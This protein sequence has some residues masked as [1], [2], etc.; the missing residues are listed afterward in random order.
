MSVR[1]QHR[2]EEPAEWHTLDSDDALRALGSDSTRGLSTDDATARLATHGPNVLPQSRGH[3]VLRLLA[4]QFADVLVILLIAAATVAVFVGEPADVVAIVAILVLN[5]ILGFAQAYRAERALDALRALSAPAAQVRRDGRDA[6]I[7][8]AELVIGDIVLLDAGTIVPADLRLVE[9]RQL[10]VEEAAL[11][12]ESVPVDKHTRALEG[13]PPLGDRRNMAFAGTFVTRGR[14]AGLVVATATRTQLG[15]IAALLRT[16]ETAATPLQRRLARLG[17]ALAI[18]VLA[19]CALIFG[20][21]LLRG[22]PPLGMLM[23][24]LSLA[25]AAVPEALPAIVTMSLALGARRMA[26]RNALVRRLPAVETL[27]SVTVICS[28]K[29]GTLTENRMRL[30]QIQTADAAPVPPPL[31]EYVAQP[32]STLLELIALNNDVT[33]AQDATRGD[34]TELAL[35][36]A[37]AAAGYR[38]ETLALRYPRIAELPF[39]SER[40]RMTTLHRAHERVIA[41]MKGAPERVVTACVDRIGER[42]PMP[43]DRRAVLTAAHD[44]AASGLRVLAVSMRELPSMPE[45]LD[46]VESD[47]TFVGLVGLLDPPRPEA[48]DAVAVCHDAGIRVVMITG[49]HPATARAIAER[50]GIIAGDDAVLTGPE[51]AR[52]S[53]ADLETRVRNVRIFSRVAAEDK[54]RIVR[55]LQQ[56]GECVAMTGDGVNDAPALR[57]AEIG[58]A[59][60]RGG[61]DVA[62]EAAAMVLLDDNFATI[63]HA[64]EEGRR[65]YDNVRRFVRYTLSTNSG[66]LWTLFAAPFIGL[67]L[68]L[69]PVQIL[70][71]NLVTDGLP[72]LSLAMERPEPGVMRRKPRPPSESLFAHGLWQH[73]LWVG[74]LMAALALGT[75]AWAI[76]SNNSHWRSMAFTVLT[77]SQLAHALAVRSERVSLLRTGLWSNRSLAGAIALTFAA[78]MAILYVPVLARVL[79]TTPLSAVELLVCVALSSVVLFAVEVEKWLIRRGMIYD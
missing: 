17:R 6:T 57:R 5:A 55:A 10:A 56:S 23:T 78:Q 16:E 3:S 79:G 34:P 64:I 19:L 47:H 72:G 62:R 15:H 21:G 39:S 8:A 66:E 26:R 63:V 54:I 41:I 48:R 25:V 77:L 1:L 12:G 20:A 13:R 35:Y 22:E 28:D 11:T 46:D 74:V 9:A 58:V 59:M 68:P 29:T 44:M 40:G 51:L 53:Q 42:G 32:A 2:A 33:V 73:T 69:L 7:G 65:I 49:D 75:Q 24:A 27:G 18:A 60:G 70:W 71:M 14:G 38:K 37:S 43:L 67:P 61:T 36:D 76:R 30:E 31:G 45:R 50:V 52:L 4:A